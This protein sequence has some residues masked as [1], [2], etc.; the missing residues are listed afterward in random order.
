MVREN[1]TA[2]K[3]NYF[4]KVIVSID[5]CPESVSHRPKMMIS[6]TWLNVFQWH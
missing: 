6:R 2:W 3:A 5:E 4:V 1:K